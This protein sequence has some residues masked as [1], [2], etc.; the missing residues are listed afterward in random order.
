MNI[1]LWHVHGSW[2]TSFVQGRH[3]YLFPVLPDRGP[4]GRGRAETWDWPSSAVEV[5]PEE[6][7]DTAIDVVILQRPHELSQLA[8]EWLGRRPGR[9][10]P[11]IYL[12]H[13]APQ[14]RV[15]DMR[16][17]AADRDDLLLVHVTHFNNLFWDAGATSTVVIEHGIVDPGYR[18]IGELERAAVV[19]N[20][21]ERRGRVTGTDLLGELRTVVPIDLFGIRTA[22]LGGIEDLPQDRLHDE[23]ARRRVYLHPI[24]WTSLGLSLIEAMHL[25]MPVVALATTEA[26]EV[27]PPEAAVV[28]NRLEVLK[29][30]LRGAVADP[31]SARV[32]GKHARDIALARFGLKRFLADWDALLERVAR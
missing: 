15:D 10:V 1:F 7:A 17:P 20:E 19:I 26:P 14:G 8:S 5:S 29:E 31:E 9:D 28:T 12:E 32:M 18:Y 24:R 21:P 11:A 22:A 13:S 3:R 4:D 6:A 27:L 25:G 23:M 2:T 16:H 30:A